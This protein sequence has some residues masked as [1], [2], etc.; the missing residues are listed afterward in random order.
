[1]ALLYADRFQS[2]Y[3]CALPYTY[4]PIGNMTRMTATLASANLGD[5]VYG[6]N[7]GPHALTQVGNMAWQY[8]HNGNLSSKPGFDYGWDFRDRLRVVTGTNSLKQSH[9]Y[10][11][12]NQRVSKWVQAA[13]GN[14]LTLYPDRMVEVRDGQ[15]IKYVFAGNTRIAEVRTPIQIVELIR[16]FA[17]WSSRTTLYPV[18]LPVALQSS[19]RL[20]VL[21]IGLTVKPMLPEA[22]VAQETTLFYH[23]D[24]LGSASVIVDGQGTVLERSSYLPFGAE[25]LRIGNSDVTRRFTGH[26]RDVD[27]GLDY[28]GARYLDVVTARFVSV[29]PLLFHD[30][31]N[32]IAQPGTLSLYAY[33]NNNPVRFSDPKG[34]FVLDAVFAGGGAVAGIAGQAISDWVAGTRSGWEAYVG[35]AVSGALSGEFMLY[36]PAGGPANIA[37]AAA[38]TS[39]AGNLVKQTLETATGKSSGFSGS[40][41]VKDVAIGAA[42]S[43]IPATTV[44][45]QNAGRNSQLAIGKSLVT[46]IERG[47]VNPANVKIATAVKAFNGFGRQNALGKSTFAS[48]VTNGLLAKNQSASDK[49]KPDVTRQIN[50]ATIS[51]GK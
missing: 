42:F 46:K 20:D 17:G 36:N 34:T 21:W 24:H 37:A 10:D 8:D 45:G 18:Y 11:H 26:V 22:E 48:G 28:A 27:I 3:I 19:V 41:F 44:L 32:L 33:G 16:G 4:N 38:L 29:D 47:S 5:M 12:A 30:A 13:Q 39:A 7:A 1:M 43:Q 51:Q 6:Q 35:A 15:L 50:A 49:A 2:G 31:E 25:R 14:K 9:T 23:A 40:D